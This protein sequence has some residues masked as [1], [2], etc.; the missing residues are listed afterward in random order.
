[1]AKEQL[2]HSDS[3]V[4][5]IWW[6]QENGGQF[7]WRGWVQHAATGESSYFHC[8]TALLTF[9]TTHTGP[10]PESNSPPRTR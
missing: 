5:R 9:I 1:M 6:E 4:V 2:H 7:S 8:V 10:L 3:F